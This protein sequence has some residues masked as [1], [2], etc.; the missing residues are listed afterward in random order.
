[1]AMHHHGLQPELRV[2]KD[3]EEMLRFIEEIDEGRAVCPD[4][5]LL[6]LNLP[7]VTGHTLLA[8]LRQSRVCGHVTVIIVSSSSATQDRE[9]AARLGATLY[10]CKPNQFDEFMQLGDIINRL[11]N[12]K[13]PAS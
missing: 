13:G 10:F 3:G 8:R 11:V 1:M 12:T 4:I 9:N 7:R 5:V 2:H 6:D